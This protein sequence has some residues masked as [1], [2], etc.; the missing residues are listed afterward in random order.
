MRVEF[1]FSAQTGFDGSKVYS[2][3]IVALSSK[4]TALDSNLTVYSAKSLRKSMLSSFTGD[5]GLVLLLRSSCTLSISPLK[6][7][8]YEL[9][10]LFVVF[11]SSS[12]L[13][14]LTCESTLLCA[15]RLISVTM[16][17]S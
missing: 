9:S 11:V 17:F 14:I 5:T 15:V 3:L 8:F 6:V 1:A 7:I 10:K 12:G 16:F 4:L 2:L 13:N